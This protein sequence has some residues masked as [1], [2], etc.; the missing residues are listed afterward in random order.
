MKYAVCKSTSPTAF[1]SSTPPEVQSSGVLSLAFW[2]LLLPGCQELQGMA[3]KSIATAQ[4]LVY[5]VVCLA[6]TLG[7]GCSTG[8]PRVGLSS[9]HAAMLLQ[10][11]SR[12]R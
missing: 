10:R 5:P 12:I 2:I 11:V 7:S 8:S 3:G 1:F 4:G 6:S 9:G